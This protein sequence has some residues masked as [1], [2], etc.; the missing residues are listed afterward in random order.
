MQAVPLCTSG[1]VSADTEHHEETDHD[2][3]D[4]DASTDEEGSGN[5]D[6]DK[7]DSDDNG[8]GDDDD[9]GDGD[10]DGDGDVDDDD[11]HGNGTGGA[12]GTD[13]RVNSAAA[14]TAGA[15][16]PAPK[17]ARTVASGGAVGAGKAAPRGSDGVGKRQSAAATM[18]LTFFR[19]AVLDLLLDHGGAM[20]ALT[21]DLLSL[22]LSNF[23]ASALAAEGNPEAMRRILEAVC[24]YGKNVAPLQRRL[25]KS[26]DTAEGLV[27]YMDHLRAMDAAE[28][29]V[30]DGA[31]L[32]NFDVPGKFSSKDLA[33][34]RG[35]PAGTAED[36]LAVF[37]VATEKGARPLGVVSENSTR[38]PSKER[39]HK[40]PVEGGPRVYIGPFQHLVKL[41]ASPFCRPPQQKGGAKGGGSEAS[42]SVVVSAAVS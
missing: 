19:K 24:R 41:A 20:P 30:L 7:D 9:D 42:S 29:A 2:R 14:G 13:T 39:L 31:W 18:A 22:S 16:V 10:G 15:G 38:L 4:K 23:C 27:A 21:D 1:F 33:E 34:G 26:K 3:E 36:S 6:E 12:L 28:F 8:D 37:R 25:K 17:K 35:P 11:G 32:S 40:F 5:D